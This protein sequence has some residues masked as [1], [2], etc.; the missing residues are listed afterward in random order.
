MSDKPNPY[1]HVEEF[2]TNKRLN[3]S[4]QKSCNRF[5]RSV[6]GIKALSGQQL[7]YFLIAMARQAQQHEDF[8]NYPMPKV[9]IIDFISDLFERGRP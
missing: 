5:R 4:I 2:E 8:K 1:F 7:E 9:T 6:D 3:E